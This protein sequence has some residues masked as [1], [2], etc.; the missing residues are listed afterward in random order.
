[1]EK[2][3]KYQQILTTFFTERAAIQDAQRNGLKA[4]LVINNDNTDFVLLK[5]G[6]K[7]KLFVHTVTFHIEIKEGKAWIYENKTDIDLA[8]ILVDMGIA[9]EDIE[10]GYLPPIL[11]Q[12]AEYGESVVA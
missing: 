7:D 9:K 12:Y 2:L 11:R 10:L 5:M 6:W 8:K 1:M 3:K 4:H